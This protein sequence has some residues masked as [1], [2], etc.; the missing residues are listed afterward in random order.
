MS[1]RLG[2]ARDCEGRSGFRL[3]RTMWNSAVEHARFIQGSF[4]NRSFFLHLGVKLPIFK[5]PESSDAGTAARILA[6]RERSEGNVGCSEVAQLGCSGAGFKIADGRFIDLAVGT[7]PLFILNLAVNDG[8]PVGGEQRPFAEG[9][10]R[11]VHAVAAQQGVLV[12]VAG[13]RRNRAGGSGQPW[14]LPRPLSR[15]RSD[16]DFSGTKKRPDRRCCPALWE[17]GAGDQSCWLGLHSSE[18]AAARLKACSRPTISLDGRRLSKLAL[19]FLS[20]SSE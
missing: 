5:S 20:W 9:V 13:A 6:W 8:E 18:A 15:R 12:A 14:S 16:F 17:C 10:A 4:K 2:G 3:N 1:A 11:D 19:S 7:S